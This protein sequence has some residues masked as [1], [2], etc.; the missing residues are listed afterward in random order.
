MSSRK[1]T[2]NNKEGSAKKPAPARRVNAQPSPKPE[3][4]GAS[5][6]VIVGIGASAGGIEALEQFFKSL[7]ANTDMAFVVVQHLAPDHES[8]LTELLARKTGM[9][10][11]QVRD[12]MAVEPNCVYVI[13]PNCDLGILHGTLQLL[14]RPTQRRPHLPVDHFFRALAQDQGNKAIGVVLSGSGSD[15]TLGLGAIKAEGGI[16]FAQEPRSAHYDNMPS[17]A[18]AAGCV[19]FVRSPRDIAQELVEIGKHPYVRHDP[20]EEAVSGGEFNKVFFLLR[21]STGHDFTNYK[22]STIAR[23][24][25]RRMVLHKLNRLDEYVRYLEESPKELKELFYDLLINVTDFF[26]D[27][28][29]FEALKSTIFPRLLEGRSADDLLR[30]WV[31]GCST[32]EEAYSI[33]MALAEYLGGDRIHRTVQIF[34]SDIDDRAIEKA[35][36]GFYP[37]NIQAHVSEERLRRF[38]TPKGNGYQISKAVRDLCV[39]STQDVIRDPPFSRIDLVSCR[40]LLIYLDPTL[41]RKVLA[42][43][44]F[45]LNSGGFLVVGTS[46]SIGSSDDLY[47]LFDK[48][49]K[50][51]LKKSVRVHLPELTQARNSYRAEVP[52]P[53]SRHTPAARNL[54]QEAERLILKRYAPPT[55]V[56]NEGMEIVS[57]TGN[58]GPYIEPT[59]GAVSFKLL[60]M[61]HPDLGPS[62]RTAVLRAIKKGAAVR[63]ENVAFRSDG[64]KRYV[65]VSIAPLQIPGSSERYYAVMFENAGIPVSRVPKTPLTQKAG[66]KDRRIRELTEEIETARG[67]MQNLVSDYTSSI[68]E[69]QTANEE[70]Q[71]S[72]EEMQSTNEEL[73]SAKEE[74]QSTNEELATMNDELEGRNIELTNV[75]DDLVNLLASVNLPIVMLDE[76]LRIRRFTP[77]AKKLLNFIDADVGRPIGDIKPNLEVPDLPGLIAEVMDSATGKSLQGRDNEGH[78]YT[79]QVRPY[80]AADNRIAGAVLVCIDVT[81][82]QR[83]LE[84]ERRLATVVRDSNDAVL[85]QDAKGNISAWNP[86]AEQLYGYSEAEALRMNINDLVPEG[87][88]E[89]YAELIRRALAGELIDGQE[90]VR[91]AK[92]G[93]TVSVMITASLLVNATGAPSAV[94]ITERETKGKADAR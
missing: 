9:K 33:A 15:G 8:L 81:E 57:F 66:T 85:V 13:P 77:M 41:Q 59:P 40:N 12:G 4:E 90:I 48:A 16:T 55:V 6:P 36:A 93:H 7:P 68:E 51:Y 58:T 70:I 18:I 23:R 64:K 75:N 50:I 27:E 54:Q 26:R 76:N 32:G 86:R 1:R 34:A 52:E 61:A 39:F 19:D 87:M 3:A 67:Q 31:P 38:F 94:A 5:T 53:P 37:E 43:F 14:N 29:M 28:Q 88:R 49:N 25:N 2:S 79:V 44:H 35:R 60:K 65:N 63:E 20:A 21:R 56:I 84:R 92:D 62:L 82:L 72:A 46:E 17:S 45:A 10:V 78:W 71:S 47:S 24:I 80:K 30:I 22:R 74:L 89:S 73:E 42:R 11:Q 69:L 91:V 83:A